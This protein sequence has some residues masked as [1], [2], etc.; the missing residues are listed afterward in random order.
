MKECIF[1]YTVQALYSHCTSYLVHLNDGSSDLLL[2]GSIFVIRLF[3]L[4][5]HFPEIIIFENLTKVA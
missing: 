5:I 2:E 3:L 1:V 4:M